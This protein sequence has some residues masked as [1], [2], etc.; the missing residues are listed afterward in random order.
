VS[1]LMPQKISQDTP[2][3]IGSARIP[4][5][6]GP[7]LSGRGPGGVDADPD[8]MRRPRRG[9]THLASA[10]ATGIEA[11]DSPGSPDASL[12]RRRGFS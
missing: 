7:L 5:L 6:S 12:S 8:S 3:G 4:S 1:P 2:R 11:M 9:R 10:K